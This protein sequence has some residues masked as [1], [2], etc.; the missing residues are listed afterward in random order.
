MITSFI[1][2]YEVSQAEFKF[3]RNAKELAYSIK[4]KFAKSLDATQYLSIF[5][6]TNR[7]LTPKKFETFASGLLETNPEIQAL[8]WVPRILHKNRL[9]F[10]LQNKNAVGK[11]KITE[12]NTAGELR[13]AGLRPVYFPVQL[14]IPR[15]GNEKAF[16]YDISSNRQ[17]NQMLK[18]AYKNNTHT[19]SGRIHLV[20]DKDNSFGI[21]TAIPVYHT[22]KIPS[23]ENIGRVQ[24]EKT[25]NLKGFVIGVY[26]MKKIMNQVLENK[27]YIPSEISLIDQSANPEEQIL[28]TTAEKIQTNRWLSYSENIRVAERNYT[29]LIRENPDVFLKD[30]WASTVFAVSGTL[31]TISLVLYMTLLQR[32]NDDL[33]KSNQRLKTALDE[34]KTLQGIIPICSYCHS[35]R[36]DEGAWNHLEAYISTHTEAIFSHGI[37]PDCFEKETSNFY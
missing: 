7:I 31:L 1:I 23:Q 25:A 29:V 17:R 12:K 2:L 4:F 30:Q 33:Y 37:C 36:N 10:E 32:K 6:N 35:I 34:I 9:A 5:L 11:F 28:F 20:Q 21:L 3:D 22:S 13:T 16:G 8:E 18:Y 27:S 15:T 19:A 24:F 26:R 14:I